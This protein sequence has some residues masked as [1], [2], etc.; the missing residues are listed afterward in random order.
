M[1]KVEKTLEKY[2]IYLGVKDVEL[3]VGPYKTRS[4]FTNLAGSPPTIYLYEYLIT[5][6]RF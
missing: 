3:V 2:K 6:R 4:A 5:M 1:D